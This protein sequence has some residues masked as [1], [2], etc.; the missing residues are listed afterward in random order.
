MQTMADR[1]R[2]KG[3]RSIRM[4]A[5]MLLAL[6]L[7]L[8]LA[9]VLANH[10]AGTSG[11]AAVAMALDA[12]SAGLEAT[13]HPDHGNFACH[14]GSSCTAAAT[15]PDGVILAVYGSGQQHFGPEPLVWS[16][17]LVRPDIKPP[18]L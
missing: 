3:V 14:G 12:D 9:P 2:R 16:A 8:A 5:L 17:R 15:L 6:G 10:R 18:I 4:V 13:A 1:E 11:G 7:L